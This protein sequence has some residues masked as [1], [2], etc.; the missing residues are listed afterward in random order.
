[1]LPEPDRRDR[2]DAE[3]RARRRIQYRFMLRGG[4]VPY[5]KGQEWYQ[6]DEV[7]E[8]YEDKRFSRGGRVIDRREKEAVL[9]ALAPLEDRAVLEIACG[10]GRFT[11]TLADRGADIVGLDISDAMLA[12]AREK[13]RDA[14]VADRLEF[15]RGDAARLP[16]PDDHFDAVFAMRFFHLADTPASFL[17][18]MCRVSRDRVF[19]DTFR[20]YSA[21][22]L[23]NWLLPMGSR[24]YSQAEVERLL[25]GAGLRL[26]RADHDFRFP[27]GFY[28]EMPGGVAEGAW[29]LDTAVGR[30]PLGPPLASVSYWDAR[31]V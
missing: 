20:R 25:S 13:A 12:E 28:R 21:R 16:F 6:A 10:T 29:R 19:F 27:F 9:D 3:E 4:T 7:A 18:E 24:L 30:T 31:V 8:Q 15:T 22:S 5:V 1:M 2:Q 23:Y 17:S 11:V 26:E 14:G